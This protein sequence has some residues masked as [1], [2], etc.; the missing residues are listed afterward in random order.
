MVNGTIR[1]GDA[2]ANGERPRSKCAHE[3]VAQVYHGDAQFSKIGEDQGR[4]AA[5]IY[6]MAFLTTAFAAPVNSQLLAARCR[7]LQQLRHVD[8]EVV[9]SLEV[10]RTPLLCGNRRLRWLCLE[11]DN[12]SKC[13][14][15]DKEQEDDERPSGHE[16]SRLCHL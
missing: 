4:L 11:T 1:S 12:D 5:P 6:F 14:D 3:S 8:R 2:A 15:K 9:Q 7:S 10:E 16:R 13:S